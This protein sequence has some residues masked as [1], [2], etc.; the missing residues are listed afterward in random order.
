MSTHNGSRTINSLHHQQQALTILSNSL[1]T[2]HS[3]NNN[4]F[5]ETKRRRGWPSSYQILQK[6]GVDPTANTVKTNPLAPTV[7]P[8]F[9]KT[10]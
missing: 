1:Y 4:E 7:T 2:N 8:R 9:P 6:Q 10:T 3:L 5:K